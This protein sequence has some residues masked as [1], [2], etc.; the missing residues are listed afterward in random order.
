[1]FYHNL[2]EF[3][4]WHFLDLPMSKTEFM[5]LKYHTDTTDANLL[6]TNLPFLC[7]YYLQIK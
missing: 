7:Y 3:D 2:N 5:F 6:L 1:M 4:F